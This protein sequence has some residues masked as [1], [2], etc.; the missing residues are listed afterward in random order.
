MKKKFFIS[1][2]LLILSNDVFSSDSEYKL[3]PQEIELLVKAAKLSPAEP[4][5][6]KKVWPAC[7]DDVPE[8]KVSK[9]TQ[10]KVTNEK[11]KL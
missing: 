11:S 8:K 5:D 3:T 1:A 6:P 2:I 4:Y 7:V 10:T 9:P